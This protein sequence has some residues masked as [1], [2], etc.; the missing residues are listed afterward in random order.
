[1]TGRV[2]LSKKIDM[3]SMIILVHQK[4]KLLLNTSII[5]QMN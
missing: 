3:Y 5:I 2:D 1:M 4:K